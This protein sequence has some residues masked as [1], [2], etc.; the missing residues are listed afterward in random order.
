MSK[1]PLERRVVFAFSTIIHS[2]FLPQNSQ[3][4]LI[5]S[6]YWAAAAVGSDR[7]LRALVSAKR[8]AKGCK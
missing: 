6:T 1:L 8:N 5:D 7:S 2:R 3:V 4:L